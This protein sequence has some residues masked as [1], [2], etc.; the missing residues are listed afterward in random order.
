[1][2][3]FEPA[4]AQAMQNSNGFRRVGGLRFELF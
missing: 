1:L 3:R 4:H 2:D